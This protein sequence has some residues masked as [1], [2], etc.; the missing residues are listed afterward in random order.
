MTECTDTYVRV[1]YM[2]MKVEKSPNMYTSCIY[3]IF[4]HICLC[5]CNNMCVSHHTKFVYKVRPASIKSLSSPSLHFHKP[6]KH[7]HPH[8]S[9]LTH[10]YMQTQ[11]THT[12]TKTSTKTSTQTN[13]RTQM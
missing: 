9:T 11:N 2:H 4:N 12:Q 10:K 3:N 1:R 5:M 7:K 6:L 8:A 13:A